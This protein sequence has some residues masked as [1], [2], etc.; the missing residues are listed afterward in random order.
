MGSGSTSPTNSLA[1]GSA[2]IAMPTVR[3]RIDPDPS[4]VK[5]STRTHANTHEPA[6]SFPPALRL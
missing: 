5:S 2:Q 6:R 1:I 4:P 3:L